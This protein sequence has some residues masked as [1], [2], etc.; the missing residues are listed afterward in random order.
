MTEV[1]KLLSNEKSGGDKCLKHLKLGSKME[2]E[3][4]SGNKLKK[5]YQIFPHKLQGSYDTALKTYGCN[6]EI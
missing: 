4:G 3:N 5:N 6:K 2:R 1:D